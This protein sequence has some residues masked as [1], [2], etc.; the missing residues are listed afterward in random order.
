MSQDFRKNKTDINAI[1]F[2]LSFDRSKF[3][4]P[5]ISVSTDGNRVLS[6]GRE[7]NVCRPD[8]VIVLN[9]HRASWM[10]SFELDF[11]KILYIFSVTTAGREFCSVLQDNA[12]SPVEQSV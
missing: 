12:E 10:A 2:S 1:Q 4:E 3:C 8:P 9:S 6:Y 5:A 7:N 11:E